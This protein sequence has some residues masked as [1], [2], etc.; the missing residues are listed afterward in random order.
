L[1]KGKIPLLILE[2]RENSFAHPWEKGKFLCSSLGK[3][4]IP[5]LILG[6]RENSYAHPWEKGKFLCSSLGKGKF[7][8]SSLG[9]GKIPL[10][11]LGKIHYNFIGVN[12]W[13]VQLFGKDLERNTGLYKVPPLTLPIREMQNHQGDVKTWRSLMGQER[14]V[15]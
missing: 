5:M 2:K 10:L 9:K 3:G 12:L 4:K 7:L 1:R 11:T 13:P 6:K 15:C 8:C 14:D